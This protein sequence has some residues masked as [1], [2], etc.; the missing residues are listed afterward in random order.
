MM[1]IEI[2]I[3]I[4]VNLLIKSSYELSCPGFFASEHCHANEYETFLLKTR[5]NLIASELNS[6]NFARE[7][8][9]AR[10]FDFE[11]IQII[12]HPSEAI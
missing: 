10:K 6:E 4:Q 3:R 11:T 9:S 12:P 2:L 8:D 1:I 5:P 7:S